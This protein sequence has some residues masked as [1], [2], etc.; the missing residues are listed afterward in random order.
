MHILVATKNSNKAQ[1]I[2]QIVQT[3]ARVWAFGDFSKL[4]LLENQATYYG[5]AAS[6][7][8]IAAEWAIQNRFWNIVG[9]NDLFFILADDSGLEV[10]A[11]S[12]A[13]GVFSARFDEVMAGTIKTQG[14]SRDTRNNSLLLKLLDG[15]IDRRARFRCILA[16]FAVDP[17]IQK[18]LPT[19]GPMFFE[20]VCEGSIIETPKGSNGFGYDPLFVPDGYNC[21]FAELQDYEKNRISHRGNAIK[22]FIDWVK[23]QDQRSLT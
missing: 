13:P 17:K 23:K 21:T 20:G 9:C 7:A 2:Q 22:H 6:K 4:D 1:E 19:N 18:I 10:D 11:L 14:D 8:R 5:N 16:V 3:L 15:V 12:G